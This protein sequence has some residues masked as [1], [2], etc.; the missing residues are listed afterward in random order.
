MA[1]TPQTANLTTT[2][3]MGDPFAKMS[4]K[5]FDAFLLSGDVAPKADPADTPGEAAAPEPAEQAASR[6]ALP[7]AAPEA[8]TPE[9]PKKQAGAKK[10]A[11]ERATEIEAETVADQERLNRA[12]Q[13][14]REVKR[15][16]DALDR[17]EKPT[18][19]GKDAEA[20][21]AK[22]DPGAPAWK[23][24]R[25]LPDAPKSAD[26]D[27][28]DDY[29]AAMGYFIAE[30][31]T[32]ERF[33]SKIQD[34]EARN[35]ALSAADREF[36]SQFTEA[37]A[38]VSAEVAADPEIHSRIDERWQRVESKHPD[39]PSCTPIEFVKSTTALYCKRPLGVA[40]YLSTPEG[41]ERLKDLMGMTKAQITRELAYIDAEVAASAPLTASEDSQDTGAV[42]RPHKRVSAAPAPA[43]VLGKKPAGAVDPLK[44]AIEENDFDTFNSIE[45]KA[46][47]ARG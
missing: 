18:K 33:D 14:R 32:D 1:D 21:A 47:S 31:I 13:T 4:E 40:T 43:K 28:L 7:E 8:A 9:K 26:F 38:R 25:A 36:E 44:K 23:K 29:A 30:K 11:A 46:A 27:D 6:D 16:L 20:A 42:E 39:D 15:Q 17:E 5:D 37:H 22:A 24:Y 10:S 45:S 19:A 12:L 35:S 3:P 34:Y 2:P 41:Y